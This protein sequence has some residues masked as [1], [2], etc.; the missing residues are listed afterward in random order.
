MAVSR[1]CPLCSL[2][3]DPSLKED[4]ILVWVVLTSCL[5]L[6]IVAGA[7]CLVLCWRYRQHP[8]STE[9]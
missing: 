1:P 5:L 3:T 4:A 2:L 9:G 6:F 8:P 7:V